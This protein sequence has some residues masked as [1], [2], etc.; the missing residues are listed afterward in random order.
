MRAGRLRHVIDLQRK[1]VAANAFGEEVVTWR[2]YAQV[3]A[4]VEAQ[5]DAEALAMHEIHGTATVQIVIRHRRDV[6]VADRAVLGDRIFEIN[7]VA[8]VDGRGVELQLAC[9][10][11][12]V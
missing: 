4:A 6:R 8:D 10:E 1:S 12:V 7:G 5:T 11:D 2:T 3:H 9:T